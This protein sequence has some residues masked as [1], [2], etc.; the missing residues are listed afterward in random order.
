MANQPASVVCRSGKL[1]NPPQTAVSRGGFVMSRHR[2]ACRAG[3]KSRSANRAPV[4]YL[5][6]V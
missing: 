5:S 2:S 3:L 6:Q 4:V 1:L